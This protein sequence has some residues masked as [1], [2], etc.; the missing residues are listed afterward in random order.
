MSEIKFKTEWLDQMRRLSKCGSPEDIDCFYDRLKHFLETGERI[1]GTDLAEIVLAPIIAEIERD[2]DKHDKRVAAGKA[3]W[4]SNAQ[5]MVEQCSSTAQAERE[6]RKREKK[7]IPPTPPIESKENKEI[8]ES[9]DASVDNTNVLSPSLSCSE[10]E[11]S[12]SEPAEPPLISLPLNNG[13]EWPVTTDMVTEWAS[14]YPAVDVLQELRKM[15]GWL[16]SKPQNRKTPRGIRAFVTTW[17][18]KEQDRGPKPTAR[19]GTGQRRLTASEIAALPFIDP[20]AEIRGT[21]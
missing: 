4:S 16:L 19:S 1:P 8:R 6:E 7:D 14:L 13:T 11:K 3:R 21:S 9:T 18:S 2:K 15:R 5:A 17:L 12:A 10:P 20:F